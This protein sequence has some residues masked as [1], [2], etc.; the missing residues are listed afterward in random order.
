MY[1]WTNLNIFK[2]NILHIILAFI[3]M[4]VRKRLGANHAVR[5]ILQQK[6]IAREISNNRFICCCRHIFWTV[7]QGLSTTRTQRPQIKHHYCYYYFL[8]YSSASY[9]V[10]PCWVMRVGRVLLFCV[11]NRVFAHGV[12]SKQ[13]VHTRLQSI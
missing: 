10:R 4:N 5:I 2:H 13:N 3:V 12:K 11:W 7:I 9:R 8:F 6:S 1:V